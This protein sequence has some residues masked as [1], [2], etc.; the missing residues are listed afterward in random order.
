ME[1]IL[2]ERR[3]KWQMRA[4]RYAQG[5]LGAFTQLAASPMKGGMMLT[6]A[7]NANQNA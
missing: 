5:A 1:E 2:A 7:E 3:A 6:D 4:P